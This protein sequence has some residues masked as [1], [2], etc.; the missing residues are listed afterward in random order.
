MLFQSL[1]SDIDSLSSKVDEMKK[2][3][4]VH[5]EQEIPTFERE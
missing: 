4:M 1:E 5:S 3:L 2:S